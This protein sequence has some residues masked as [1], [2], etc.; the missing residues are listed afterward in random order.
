M[1]HVRKLRWSVCCK[2]VTDQKQL[3]LAYLL[4]YTHY[5]IHDEMKLIKCPKLRRNKLL[6]SNCQYRGW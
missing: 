1:K 2:A 4:N 5:N 6:F 3:T